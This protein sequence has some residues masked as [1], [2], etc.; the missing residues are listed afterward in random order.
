MLFRSAKI[1]SEEKTR[2]IPVIVMSSQG[3]PADSQ[4]AVEIGANHIT[5]K[6]TQSPREVL[7][8]IRELM[9]P[10]ETSPESNKE[11]RSYR[12][13]VQDGQL[14]ALKLQRDIGL[15]DPLLCRH[16]NSP[17]ILELLTDG[18]R[19]SEFWFRAHFTCPKCK[20]KS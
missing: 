3:N 13:Y 14:D 5:I 8:K 6:G 9:P 2:K 12:L 20:K 1:R 17:V 7:A 11:P 4:K 16:C 19:S 10:L 15:T 18:I